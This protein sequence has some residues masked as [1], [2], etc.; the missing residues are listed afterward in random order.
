MIK[1]LADRLF[2]WFCHP[3]YYDE[4]AGDL[5]ELYQRNQEERVRFV[6]WLYFFQVMG[7]FRL[8]LIRAFPQRYLT[9]PAM[10][11]HYFNIS[12]RVLL[13]HKFY[14]AINIL[15]LAVGMGVCL[16][17]YQYIHFE[18]SYDQFHENS[19]NIYRLTQTTIRNGEDL[20]TGIYTTYGLGP[21]GKENI[22]EV[23]EFVRIRP[24]DVGL[25]V[26]NSE[27]NI[28]HQENHIWYVDSTFL[29]MFDFPLNYGSNESALDEQ[30]NIVLTEQM[31]HKYFGDENPL[32]KTLS[33]SAGTLSGDF[34]VSGVL[35]DLPAN[36]HLQFDF[37]LPMVFLLDN[38]RMYRGDEG[39]DW[40]DFV[41]YVTLNE[42]AELD[43]VMEKFDQL[44]ATY[45]RTELAKSNTKWKID[46][47]HLTDIHL[48]SDFPK[49][50][51]SNH[52]DI[53][54]VQ[55][56]AIIGLFILLIAWVNYINLS[57][58]RSMQRGKEVGVRKSIGAL[59]NQLISQFMI[60]AALINAIAAL[61]SLC[62]AYFTLPVLN[63]IIGVELAFNVLQ[64]PVFWIVFV[65]NIL[66]GTLLSGLYPAFLLSSF[67]PLKVLKSVTITPGRGFSLRKGLIAFQFLMSVLLT[68]GTYLVYQQITFMKSRDLGFDLERILVVN[69]PRVVL[70][71]SKLKS[72][73]L[74]PKYQTFKNQV[75]S[76]HSIASVSGNSSIPGQG[77]TYNFS[78]RKLG[79]PKH[80]KQAG[81][82]LL[83]DDYF[84]ETYNLEFLA[85]GDFEELTRRDGVILNEEALKI[86]DL[87]KPSEAID[88]NLIFLDDTIRVHG[89]IK[90][91]HW[92]SLKNAHTP[93]FFVHDNLYNVYFSI[94]IN[95]SNIQESIA[96]IKSAYQEVFP[97]DPFH[98]FFL[99]DAF[100]Q[101]YQADLQFRNL[102]SVFSALAIFIACIGLFALVS[103]SAT[104]RIKEIGIRKVLGAGVGHLMILLSREYLLLL[105][106]AVAVPV[107][108][109]G[110]KVW[111][112]N[113]AY[114]VGI[115]L[116]L[117]LIPGLMLLLI[118]FLT[119]SYRTYATAKTNPVESLKTE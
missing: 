119:V 40:E 107:I 68:S 42:T 11:R 96:H 25:I 3:D 105:C 101:Q 92:S 73:D 38:W 93:T 1:R 37:L 81:N 65:L 108:L 71:T 15:G 46:L 57:T 20:G 78:I 86:L 14:T 7:L 102:F 6:Q 70:E 53:R 13:K 94:K 76:H 34:I 23:E 63:S 28:R 97:D 72:E 98:Y 89:V 35:E 39:W 12:T 2:R 22:P 67:N 64:I 104:L 29:H 113:Y 116:D 69:G 54:N 44:V 26:I 84:A 50:L 49:D 95:T 4:I 55:F 17:I 114:Q 45:T 85:G 90:N 62:I 19:E 66:F 24:D 115:S 88:E 60:E 18:L 112:E 32:G 80:T 51:A 58:A 59:K 21:S 99:D 43:A 41:T 56:F 118:S 61:F 74:A 27:R 16:L 83:V 106:I 75:L 10:F 47:Q 100:N 79:E 103:Y 110:G 111:L 77:Y 9:H 48:K 52:E 117:F 87:G 33:I 109:F 36:S 82:L 30:H 31:A 5:E 91:M 8:S